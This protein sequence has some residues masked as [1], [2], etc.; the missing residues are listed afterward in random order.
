MSG[1]PCG[2][3]PLAR[4]FFLPGSV[5]V[6]VIFSPGRDTAPA[7]TTGKSD[8]FDQRSRIILIRCQSGQIGRS[9]FESRR[10]LG[11][12][13]QSFLRIL[14]TSPACSLV[15]WRMGRMSAYAP[16]SPLPSIS[17]AFRFP[18]NGR[19]INA[20]YCELTMK[21]SLQANEAHVPCDLVPLISVPVPVSQ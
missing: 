17:S 4:R 5:R 19:T 1:D 16:A 13:T 7:F 6:S 12:I 3:A 8:S 21:S 9:S 18:P 2:G 10:P 15:I 14:G 20:L 11:I